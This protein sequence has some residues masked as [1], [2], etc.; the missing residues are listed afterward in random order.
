MWQTIET[1]PAGEAVILYGKDDEGPLMQEGFYCAEWG[2]ELIGRD[3]T[4]EFIATH[5]HPM[6]DA[7]EDQP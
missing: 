2:A 6:P 4:G 5:W 3:G 1:C 7:P